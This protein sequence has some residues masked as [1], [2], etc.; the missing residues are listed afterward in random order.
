MHSKH[1]GNERLITIHTIVVKFTDSFIFYEQTSKKFHWATPSSSWANWEGRG[2]RLS[3]SNM[4]SHCYQSQM[5]ECN[6]SFLAF[7]PFYQSKKKWGK[8]NL[9]PSNMASG[10]YLLA[11]TNI[12]ITRKANKIGPQVDIGSTKT[13]SI[14]KA[15]LMLGWFRKSKELEK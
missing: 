8:K 5:S 4:P 1:Q 2:G 6:N 15:F 10:C 3:E 13:R 12:R 14:A 7:S 9:V 11:C